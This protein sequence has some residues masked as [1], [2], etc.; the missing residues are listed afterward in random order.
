MIA[1]GGSRA[2]AAAV[3]QQRQVSARLEPMDLPM[4]GEQ[5]ELDE[6]VAAAAGAELRP[7]P[8]LV[9]PGDRAHVP[10]R[11]Q[12]L[13]LA[14]VF[15]GGTHAEAGLRFDCAG[16]A[17]RVPLQFPQRD[18]E[19]R[20]LHATGN[21]HAN[22]VRNDG[23]FCRQHA[24]DGQSIADVRVRHQG[25]CHGHWQQ[26]GLLHLHHGFVFQPLTPLPV[27]NRFS[28]WRRRSILQGFGKFAPQIVLRQKPTD[29][30]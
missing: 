11:V 24:A 19:H 4:G 9:L 20:H 14:A 5:A 13:V 1:H 28:A 7:G 8:V 21:I 18:I 12:D 6:M 30:R 27:L 26:A 23:V 16:E 2:A 10:V 25:T 17:L 29:W 3:G 22:R 15:E